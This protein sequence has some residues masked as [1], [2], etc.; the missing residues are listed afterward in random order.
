MDGLA[1]TRTVDG[2]LLNFSAEAFFN[3]FPPPTYSLFAKKNFCTFL[4][5][6]GTKIGVTIWSTVR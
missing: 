2:L 1:S 4:Q 3:A 6:L 5:L